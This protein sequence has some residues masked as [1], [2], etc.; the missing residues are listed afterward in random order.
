MTEILYLSGIGDQSRISELLSHTQKPKSISY[1]TALSF[2]LL[3]G[4]AH[5]EVS[6]A[7]LAAMYKVAGIKKQ[8]GNFVDA[9]DE[10][11][12]PESQ[13]VDLN[14]DG[15]P[16]VFLLI[17]GSCYGSAG[18]E[19]SL[20]IKNKRG[21]WKRNLGFPAGGYRLLS[22]SNKG[23]PDIEIDGPGVCFP[24]WRWNGTV[25]AIHKRCDR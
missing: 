2:L 25:Y 1:A 13:V 14:G 3:A 15:N 6:Q 16:E 10:I 24:V 12:Q 8:G 19:L 17:G 18:T 22:T 23:Y 7:D 20:F 5:S 21:Q 11:F 4:I 9:C